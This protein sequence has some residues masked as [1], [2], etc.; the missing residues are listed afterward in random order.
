MHIISCTIST[1]VDRCTSRRESHCKVFRRALR[2]SQPREA[3]AR[4]SAIADTAV[5]QSL[6]TRSACQTVSYENSRSHEKSWRPP[7]TQ[8]SPPSSMN[9]P[10]PLFIRG[11]FLSA[12]FLVSAF[13]CRRL[14]CHSLSCQPILSAPFFHR[15]HQSSAT[16]KI[17]AI[18]DTPRHIPLA[19]LR[20]ISADWR[21]V[22]A[23]S[24]QSTRRGRRWHPPGREKS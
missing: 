1:L 6:A 23:T 10:P 13:S 22:R 18:V 20:A 12:P 16:S 24:L 9:G 11:S 4:P 8:G 7:A 2:E 17:P 19:A 3:N 5:N 21:R 15:R 14:S